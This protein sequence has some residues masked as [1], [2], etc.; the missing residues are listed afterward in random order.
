M[1][2]QSIAIFGEHLLPAR[3]SLC[4]LSLSLGAEWIDPWCQIAR[5][6]LLRKKAVNA[7][8]FTTP[9]VDGI[10]AAIMAP[11]S[12]L[13]R[14]NKVNV[15]ELTENQKSRLSKLLV[16]PVEQ[17]AGQGIKRLRFWD[18]AAVEPLTRHLSMSDTLVVSSLGYMSYSSSNLGK[19]VI[20]RYCSIA[21][22][23]R[24]IGDNHPTD[25]VTTHVFAYAPRYKNILRENGYP[26]WDA[27]SPARL[28]RPMLE[29]GNDVWIG[30][31]V[32]LGRGIKIGNGAVIAGS[33]VV[34]KDVP[35][36]AVYGGVPARL[37]RYRFPEDTIER[38]LHTK[39]W[40]Y[41]ISNFGSM[42]FNDVERFLDQFAELSETWSKMPDLRMPIT[43]ILSGAVDIPEKDDWL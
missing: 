27:V 30:R 36:Y 43:D 12:K 2:R 19:A 29:I 26:D 14:G 37:I 1:A 33:A 22:N 35:P 40:E 13:R 34:T 24:L 42:K 17:R 5:S 39:W 23:V 9:Q 38:L 41:R 11:Q 20:G 6:I 31:D 4:L 7:F 8:V 18:G 10:R 32:V 3:T 15:V 21:G 25:W 16:E 28:K